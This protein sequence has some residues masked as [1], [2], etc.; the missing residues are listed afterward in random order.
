M[1]TQSN[2]SKV[3]HNC[4]TTTA[5]HTSAKLVLLEVMIIK[6]LINLVGKISNLLTMPPL[7][8]KT[9]IFLMRM[10][11]GIMKEVTMMEDKTAMV[12]SRAEPSI[13]TDNYTELKFEINIK[14]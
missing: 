2:Q 7:F 13:R 6:I 1:S 11:S 4:K 8:K 12:A 14:S 10:I 9:L 3:L 5:E